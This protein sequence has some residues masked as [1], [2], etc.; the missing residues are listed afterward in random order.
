MSTEEVVGHL[1]GEGTDESTMSGD[2]IGTLL[3]FLR[4][5]LGLDTA[6]LSS[7]R[8]GMQVF[9]VLD[10]DTGAVGL[11]C[12]DRLSLAGSYCLR[13]VDGRLPAV[14]TDTAANRITAELPVTRELRLGAYVGVTL[15]DSAGAA[16]GS[17]CLVSSHAKPELADADLRMVEQVAEFIGSLIAPVPGAEVSSAQRAAIRRVVTE[18]DFEVVFQ[19]VHDVTTC[20]VVGVEALTRFPCEPFRPDLF[21]EQAAALGVDI[22]LQIAVRRVLSL[23]PELPEGVFVA[24]NVSPMAALLAPWAELL[25]G[26]DPS[27][28]VLEIT[29][30]DAVDDYAALGEVLQGCRLRG[31]RIAVDDVG[32]GFASLTHVLELAPEV[33]KID[34]SITR[35]IDV[36]D[37]RRLLMRAIAEF[38]GQT[39]ATV[40]AEGVETQGELDALHDAGIPWAQGY[41]LS[42]PKPHTHGFPAAEVSAEPIDPLSP[43]LD[44]DLLGERRFGLA[45]TH[46]PIGMAVVGLDGTFLRTNPALGAILGYSKLAL[47]ALTFQEITHPDD[48]AADLDLVAQCLQGHRRTYRINKRF[49]AADGRVVWC[50]LTVV[51]VH[52]SHDRSRRYFV[53]QIVDKTTEPSGSTPVPRW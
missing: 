5:R 6:W 23:V 34:Q 45:F 43:D 15:R 37:S 35:N 36:D 4:R 24:V 46:S 20:A 30:H 41:Y 21:F 22:E 1:S 10:G 11:S 44:L 9:E 49:L 2:L 53:S 51:F 26:V 33:V 14:V 12:G 42:R 17:L 27:R 16:V 32:A 18:R 19:A 25:A 40:I 48:L 3:G 47:A 29:E 52:G 38:A 39:G 28:I 31:M 8:D 50:D 13:V 7:F